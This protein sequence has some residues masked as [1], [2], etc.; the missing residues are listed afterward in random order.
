MLSNMKAM[1]MD[2]RFEFNTA[3]RGGALYIDGTRFR[4]QS[5]VIQNSTFE[6]NKAFTEGGALSSNFKPIETYK[7][8]YINNTCKGENNTE[9]YKPEFIAFLVKKQDANNNFTVF[10]KRT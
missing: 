4:N 1:I 10:P 7:N 2:S 3:D 5:V 6:Y 8:T 9:I